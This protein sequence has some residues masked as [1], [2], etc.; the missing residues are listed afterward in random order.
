MKKL[1]SACAAIMCATAIEAKTLIVYYSFTN[2]THTIA[3]ELQSQTGA[4]LLRIEPAEE[5]LDYAANNYAIGSALIQAIRNAPDDAASYPAIKPTNINPADYDTIII[6]APLWWSNMAA[7]LQTFLFQHGSQMKGKNI[8][9]IVSSASSGI[10]GVETDMRRLVPEGNIISP[11]LWIRSS[12]THS[13]STMIAEWLEQIGYTSLTSAISPT[14]AHAAHTTLTAQRGNISIK[15]R[16]DRFCL[17]TLGGKE[18]MQT[19]ATHISTAPLAPGV[20]VG[21][22]TAGGRTANHK[23]HICN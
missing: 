2:N 12:Q 13:C 6:G 10:S 23:L 5:D 3:T 22:V 11:S 14:A 16:F 15:G 19:T 1:L 20:Y 7:P 17:Y 9:L 8:A 18:V 4:D 21:K